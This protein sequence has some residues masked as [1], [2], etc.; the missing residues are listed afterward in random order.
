MDTR[1]VGLIGVGKM[2]VG[3]GKNLLTHGFDVLAFDKVSENIDPL[4]EFNVDRAGSVVEIAETAKII[5]TCLPSV[6]SI[7]SVY[8][9]EQ[10]LIKNAAAGAVLIDCSS[11]N[12]VLTRELGELAQK[13]GIDMVDAPILRGV[14]DAWAGTV[15]LVVGGDSDVLDRCKKVFD[16]VAEDTIIAGPLGSAHT[17]KALNNQVTLS[18]HVA[19]CETFA[20]AKKMEIDLNTLFRVMDASQAS[21]K[22]L[23]DLAPRLIDEN[24]EVTMTVD[25][26]AK[27][28]RNFLGLANELGASV[29]VSQAVYDV[30]QETSE[31]GFGDDCPTRIATMLERKLGM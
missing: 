18:N 26:A 6:N 23:K 7:E 16:A 20:V 28:S 11:G 1:K 27:D 3:L 25:T 21:S 29:K 24:H 15:Q 22:K 17:I 12:P 13:Q 9:S 5:I 2:G 8:K 30:F 4:D 10:G 31:M 14:P 19:I